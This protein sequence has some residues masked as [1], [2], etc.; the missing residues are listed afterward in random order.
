MI[1]LGIESTA[2]TFSASVIKEKKIL[3][4]VREMYKS[5]DKK[6]LYPTNALSS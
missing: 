5:E 1:V 2:H 3:S 6:E 4:E